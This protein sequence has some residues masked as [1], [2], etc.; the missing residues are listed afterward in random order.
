MAQTTIAGKFL[1]PTVISAL[2]AITD[3]TSGTDYLLV[4]DASDSTLKKLL[5]D[6]LGLGAATIKTT[7]ASHGLAVG[8]VVKPSGTDNQYNKALATTAANAEVVGIVT[9]VSGNDVTI[10]IS[11]EITTGAVSGF[12]YADATAGTIL[13]LSASA[14]LLTST[15]PTTEGQ[16]SKPV[17]VITQDDAKIVLIIQRGEVIST[18]VQ[19]DAPND[20][21]YVTLS[22]N[23]TL[24]AERTLAA[25]SGITLTDAGANGAATISIANDAIDS[26]H[27]N[28]ASIDNEHLADDAVN[29]DELAAGSVDLAHMSS[30]SVDEDNLYIS[31]AGSNG[32]FLSKQSGNSGGLTWAAPGGGPT[33][34]SQ[35]A[36]LAGT[37][38]DTYI[39]PD[40]LLHSPGASSGWVSYRAQDTNAIKERHNVAS[41]SDLAS[42]GHQE[43]CWLIDFA[44]AT[45]AFA[46]GMSAST[47]YGFLD[48]TTNPLVGSV[49]WVTLN[50]ANDGTDDLYTCLIAYGELV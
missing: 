11:G 20:A 1:D 19:T 10:T 38:E 24:T 17:A 50:Q 16:I 22:T 18:G 42:A 34:A 5:P 33:K 4:W 35:A 21:T 15:E 29:S 41:V 12:D 25:G 43:V 23:S 8:D 37:E 36:I 26:Q 2:D 28:A 13:F 3:G 48:A 9:V 27:Y 46:I 39:P 30:Q 49:H 47:G 32:E 7:Y 45:Y 31:N 6:N 44:A 40:L 14:G